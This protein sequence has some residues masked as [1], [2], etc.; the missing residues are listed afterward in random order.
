MEQP[1]GGDDAAVDG[2]LDS[3]VSGRIEYRS[4]EGVRD[5]GRKRLI[6]LTVRGVELRSGEIDRGRQL[7]KRFRMCCSGVP[8]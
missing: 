3:A 4:V 6:G 7:K 8:A 1:R 2:G 5:I